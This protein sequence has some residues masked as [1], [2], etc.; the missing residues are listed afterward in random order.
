MAIRTLAGVAKSPD[1]PLSA[2]VTAASEL[3]DRGWGRAAVT[4]AGEDGGPIQVVI[5]Q[6]VD[7]IDHSKTIEHEPSQIEPSLSQP[8]ER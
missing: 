3:L 5:R 4:V 7:I 2:R 6:L 1:A 8:D